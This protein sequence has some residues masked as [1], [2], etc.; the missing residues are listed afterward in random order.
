M[1]TLLIVISFLLTPFFSPTVGTREMVNRTGAMLPTI[2]INAALTVDESIYTSRTPE[3]FDIVVV[4]R[5]YFQSPADRTEKT[6]EIVSRVI[7][8]SGEK[9]A[10]RNGRIF[11]NGKRVLEPFTTKNCPKSD[12]KS[13]PCR[14]MAAVLIPGD[15]FFL[16][17]D[18]RAESEDSRSWFPQTIKR[19]DVVG[20]V[21]KIAR[22]EQVP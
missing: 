22:Q 17:A 3:R 11:I 20:K 13:F 15:E 21:V 1:R 9:I 7:G 4:R 19:S 8:L 12:D 18:N 14:E 6:M 16:L 10:L 2:P 5:R